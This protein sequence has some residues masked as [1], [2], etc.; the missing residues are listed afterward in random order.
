MSDG[1]VDAFEATS[2]DTVLGIDPQMHP[3][4]FEFIGIVIRKGHSLLCP[5]C[6]ERPGQKSNLYHDLEAIADAD[7]Q[8]AGLNKFRQ[9]VA[10]LVLD[11][12]GKDLASGHIVS[13]TESARQGEDL[14]IA[15]RGRLLSEAPD[16][17]DVLLCSGLFKGEGG[18][19]ITVGSGCADD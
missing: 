13:I 3:A 14:V 9:S 2:E 5:V 4:V 15:E 12:V 16:V 11:F 1:D 17:N 8:L 7:D 18:F 10:E 6:R 19:D